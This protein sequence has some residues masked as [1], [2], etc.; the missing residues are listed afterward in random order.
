MRDLLQILPALLVAGCAGG[1]SSE[2][3][4]N[5]D[6]RAIGFT[7]GAQGL[8]PAAL[9][10]LQE[11][12]SA[13][14]GVRADERAYL[15]GRREGLSDYCSPANGFALG[16]QGDG[17][18]NICPEALSSRFAEA[19]RRGEELRRLDLAVRGA[20]AAISDIQR[21]R[22]ELRRR[23]AEAE[24]LVMSPSTARERRVVYQEELRAL[25]AEN[26]R[27]AVAEAAR[28]A[29]RDRLAAERQAFHGQYALEY[30]LNGGVVEPKRASY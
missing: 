9:T 13:K 19:Y 14:A 29:D 5:A 3:C 16:A 27:L 20:E 7:D 8:A 22:W 23:I 24:T 12:C 28:K 11:R 26:R 30:G 10:P 25:E 17:R 6:W 18:P 21:E 2:A 1:M 4:L 15:A